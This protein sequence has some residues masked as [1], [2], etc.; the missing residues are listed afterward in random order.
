MANERICT[1]NCVNGPC[2]LILMKTDHVSRQAM[3]CRL[4]NL[5]ISGQE[6]TCFMWRLIAGVINHVYPKY[7]SK[8]SVVLITLYSNVLKKCFPNYIAHSNV[9]QY[10]LQESMWKFNWLEWVQSLDYNWKE[11]N[12]WRRASFFLKGIVSEDRTRGRGVHRIPWAKP[13]GV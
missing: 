13:L 12:T 5:N 7:F 4:P 11:D 2:F 1:C 8:W 10:R 9:N 3:I 6:T